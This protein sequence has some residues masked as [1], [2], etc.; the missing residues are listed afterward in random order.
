M[1]MLLIKVYIYMFIMYILLI[2]MVHKNGGYRKLSKRAIA[3]IEAKKKK[4]EEGNTNFGS[5]DV[6]VVDGKAKK[7][8]GDITVIKTVT[9]RLIT[10]LTLFNKDFVAA[11]G[12]VKRSVSGLYHIEGNKAIID[13]PVYP[14]K[15]DNKIEYHRVV[16]WELDE[17]EGS[18]MEAYIK[19]AKNWVPTDHSTATREYNNKTVF[20]I[21]G[22][23]LGKIEPA[24]WFKNIGKKKGTLIFHKFK[25][26]GGHVDGRYIARKIL[27]VLADFFEKRVNRLAEV[28][29][30]KGKKLFDKMAVIDSFL[31]RAIELFRDVKK[32]AALL[33]LW[34]SK[35]DGDFKREEKWARHF[36]DLAKP[37]TGG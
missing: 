22:K 19:T 31:R 18:K 24:F 28:M 9:K 8:K 4:Q 32:A 7:R 37:I 11:L 23:Q 33:N 27:E 12:E 16:L 13:I 25:T 26:K 15:F 20:F 2:K 34:E 17:I 21:V 3:A 6:T 10:S 1:S 14:N 36:M 30:D 35:E 5:A 29:G